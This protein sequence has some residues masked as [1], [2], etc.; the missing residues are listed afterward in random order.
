MMKDRKVGAIRPSIYVGFRDDQGLKSRGY[1][2]F[3]LRWFPRGPTMTTD[4][5]EMIKDRKVGAIKPSPYVG[6]PRSPTIKATDAIRILSRG[7]QTCNLRWFSQ[8]P[9]ANGN[10]RSR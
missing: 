5:T 2:T 3:N 9:V 6:F 1:Q 4:A 8:G 10:G 7:Y